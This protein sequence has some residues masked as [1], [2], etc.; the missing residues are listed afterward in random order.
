ML[1]KN[2]QSDRQNVGHETPNVGVYH[3]KTST[4]IGGIV[5]SRIVRAACLLEPFSVLHR[6]VTL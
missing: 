3:M 1:S 5:T 6:T 4:P 2:T